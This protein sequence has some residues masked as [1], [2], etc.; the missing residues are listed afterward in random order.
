MRAALVVALGALLAACG[1]GSGSDAD[2]GLDAGGGAFTGTA[3]CTG[4]QMV[5][6]GG[7]TLTMKVC[8]EWTGLSAQQAVAYRAGC[9]EGTFDA[10]TSTQQRVFANVPCSHEGALGACRVTLL[11]VT[12]TGWYY[13]DDT[14]FTV[15]AIQQLCAQQGGTFVAP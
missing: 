14:G 10:S 1:S 11:G 8:A 6:Q 4:T 3:S 5:T 12:Q 7:Q 15:E 13:D 2:G 9:G